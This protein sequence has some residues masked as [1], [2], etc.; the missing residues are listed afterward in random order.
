MSPNFIIIGPPK[1]ASTSLHNYLG[2]HPEIFTTKV[3]ET[4]FFSW[5][6]EKGMSHYEEYFKDVTTEKAI[7]ETTPSYSFLPF[8]ADRI[9]AHF[10]GI[11]LILC[12]R[13]PVDRTFSSWLMQSSMGSEKLSL[14]QAI[15]INM[16]QLSYVTLEGEEG[17]KTWMDSRGN[18]SA[19]E[20]RLRTYI[21]GGMYAQILKNYYKRFDKEQ[22]KV[23][24]L[25]DLKKDFDGTMSDLF[26]FLNVDA[27]FVIP[28]K[29]IVNFQFDRKANKITNKLFGINGTRF[30]IGITPKFLKKKMKNAWKTKETPKLN[31]E[32]K[33]YLWNIFKDDVA[34]L[35]QMLGRN[36]QHWNPMH[37]KE[38]TVVNG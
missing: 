13:N 6:Y 25:D 26:A 31:T 22:V 36:L 32:E 10:P 28:N 4:R 2:Q 23:I 15:D 35:E 16:K 5:N 30:L 38:A 9:K 27:N 11:K 33:L 24:F 21:Q 8:V 7:G 3:K 20:T 37:K 1:C 12:F 29:E 19:D 34:E 18:F 17:A 14:Q